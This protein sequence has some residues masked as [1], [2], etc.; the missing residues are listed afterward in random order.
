LTYFCTGGTAKFFSAADELGALVEKVNGDGVKLV[1]IS[2]RGTKVYPGGQ[3]DTFCVDHWRCR[4]MSDTD[5]GTLTKQQV[6]N[7][8]ARF[9]ENNLDFIKTEHL[10]NFDGKAG[11]ALG[12]GQ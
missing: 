8:L 12:Q 7:L 10:Y 9:E 2:N 5:G 1:M 3:P 6:I 11:Y 4:F